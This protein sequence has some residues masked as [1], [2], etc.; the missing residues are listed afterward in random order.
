MLKDLLICYTFIYSVNSALL[1]IQINP[2]IKIISYV[3]HDLVD[4]FYI[5]ED[6]K[7]NIL[8]KRSI[9]SFS[10]DI[11]NDF[12]AKS[13]GKFSTRLSQHKMAKTTKLKKITQ[14]FIIFLDALNDFEILERI[15]LVYRHGDEAIKFFIFI[16]NI[17]YEELRSSWIYKYYRKLFIVSGGVFHHSYFITNE[18]NTVTLSTVEYF[19]PY[20]CN[21]PYLKK[22][23][24]FYKQSMT[25]STELK[26]YEKF[27]QYYGCK[28]VMMLPNSDSNGNLYHVSGYSILDPNTLP[29]YD[30]KGITPIIFEIAAKHHNFLTH[31][32]PALVPADWLIAEQN[33]EVLMYPINKTI[34]E[35]LVFFEVISLYNAHLGMRVSNVVANLNVYMVVTPAEKYT[36]YE[37][38]FL[39]FDL[40]TWILFFVTFILTFLVIFIINCFSKPVQNL[41]YGNKVDTP[42]W[43]IVCIFFGVSQMKLPNSNFS[44]FI[45]IMFIYFCLIFRTCFQSKFFEF[46]TS[47]P[48]QAPPKTV[49][50]LID[51]EYNVYAMDVNQKLASSLYRTERWYCCALS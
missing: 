12:L 36:P 7:F 43:N 33:Q 40:W 23:N 37:K 13:N 44:R 45:W 19:S 31:Y 16:P 15:F 3:L 39:P 1:P 38:F 10:R 20:G 17:T 29:Y 51:R 14:S 8:N 50:D 32:Q 47:E 5:N 9:S 41:V 35:P 30:I 48:R 28:L 4:E 18:F 22:L 21:R 26:N 46:M 2:D 42:I 24:I 6:I 34:L 27:L 11:L 25:W 49:Q